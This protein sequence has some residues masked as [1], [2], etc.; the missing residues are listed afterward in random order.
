MHKFVDH[1]KGGQKNT[2]L[3]S[4][5]LCSS[6][7]GLDSAECK[8]PLAIRWSL[9]AASPEGPATEGLCRALK[10]SEMTAGKGVEWEDEQG[11]LESRN[12][13]R[14]EDERQRGQRE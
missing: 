11:R 9:V 4:Q 14:I 12:E 7:L 6:M 10:V 2:Q 5:G 3:L 13:N 8:R 1:R